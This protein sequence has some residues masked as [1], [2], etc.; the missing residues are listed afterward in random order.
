MNHTRLNIARYEE[1]DAPA[2]TTAAAPA[3]LPFGLSAL[4]A[5]ITGRPRSR[6][7][8][9]LVSVWDDHQGRYR[10]VDLRNP[11]DPLWHA[12]KSLAAMKKRDER[13]QRRKSAA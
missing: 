13:A 8:P 7:Q 5:T 6:K 11:Q 4:L 1:S 3:R 10:P 2:K 9:M 12:A